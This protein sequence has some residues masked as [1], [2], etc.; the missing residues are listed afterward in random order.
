MKK[1][2]GV[3][4]KNSYEPLAML[5][6]KL[7][8]KTLKPYEPVNT[9]L[10]YKALFMGARPTDIRAAF[11]ALKKGA[12]PDVINKIQPY[13]QDPKTILEAYNTYDAYET[14]SKTMDE[15]NKELDKA[16][17]D[18]PQAFAKGVIEAQEAKAKDEVKDVKS[19][20][21][22]VERVETV[23]S[24]ATDTKKEDKKPV[25]EIKD[26]KSIEKACRSSAEVKADEKTETE[27]KTTAKVSPRTGTKGTDAAKQAISV[28]KVDGKK[29]KFVFGVRVGSYDKLLR[30]L[31]F[32]DE[33]INANLSNFEMDSHALEFVVVDELCHKT[34][35]DKGTLVFQMKRLLKAY[36]LKYKYS[37]LKDDEHRTDRVKFRVGLLNAA[38]RFE[39]NGNHP[40][41]KTTV[42]KA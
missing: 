21:K 31:G 3:W 6:I 24:K 42:A 37:A 29:S 17:P 33:Y 15:I 23:E 10:L 4:F 16:N 30:A 35:V 28:A 9:Y 22:T 41:N 18:T 26:E 19:D 40:L 27:I 25:I 38:K 32:D 14:E 13:L 5:D 36:E 2:Y 7:T 34:K 11:I 8:D 39:L 20:T 1:L 12:F